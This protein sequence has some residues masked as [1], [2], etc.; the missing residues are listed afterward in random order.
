MTHMRRSARFVARASIATLSFVAF[1]LHVG[2]TAIYLLPGSPIRNELGGK[3][4]SDYMTT[5]FS[6]DWHLFSPNPGTTSTKLWLRCGDGVKWSQYVDPS[7][8]TLHQHYANRFTPASRKLYIYRHIAEDLSKVASDLR[9][10][11]CKGS[12]GNQLLTCPAFFDSLA[13]TKEYALAKRFAS[14]VCRKHA[15][16][17]PKMVQMMVVR[18]HP[19]PYSKRHELADKLFSKAS[20]LELKQEAI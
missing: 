5:Y 2:A 14:D 11:S 18:T 10:N 7:W 19:I 4:V 16:W 20:Y 9:E 13:Q 1:A 8:D 17:A 12:K 3:V 6:Q 15:T